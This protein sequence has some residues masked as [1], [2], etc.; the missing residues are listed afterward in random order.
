LFCSLPS[1]PAIDC[2]SLIYVFQMAR[3]LAINGTK[4]ARHVS[5][6]EISD[7]VHQPLDDISLGH[8]GDNS[9]EA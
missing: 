1:R 9:V 8:A 7:T 6:D 5:L 2:P 3:N 4:Q